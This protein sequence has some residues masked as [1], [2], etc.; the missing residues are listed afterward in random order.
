MAD[1]NTPH[2]I[3]PEWPAPQQIIAHTTTR[4][5]GISLSPYDSFNLAAHVGDNIDHVTH[6]RKALEDTL[7]LNYSIQWLKQVHSNHAINFDAPPCNTQADACFTQACHKVCAVLT[8]DCLPILICND[9][10]T[11]VAAIHAGWKGL[12]AGIIENT[13]SQLNSAAGR[14]YAWLGPAIGPQAFQVNDRIRLDFIQKIEQNKLAFQQISGDWFADIYELGRIALKSVG[15]NQIYG[16]DF[17][18][19]SDSARFY[20]Y[21]RDGENTGRMASLIYI[22]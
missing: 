16:G 12:L 7:E 19:V 11:E 21:R 5:Q 1:I 9:S 17:C 20:S 15:V 10:G 8:A 6:N 14:L 3:Q 13:I 2:L 18:T 22:K 4:N